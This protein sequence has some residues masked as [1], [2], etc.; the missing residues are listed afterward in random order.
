MVSSVLVHHLYTLIQM[1]IGSLHLT[2]MHIVFS[3]VLVCL[4]QN[5][6]YSQ[7]DM[8]PIL[9][10]VQEARMDDVVLLLQAG[11]NILSLSEVPC[12]RVQAVFLTCMQQG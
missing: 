7:E 1:H 9:H 10:A 11:A 4:S 5:M 8:T 12:T 6:R 2:H 3:S